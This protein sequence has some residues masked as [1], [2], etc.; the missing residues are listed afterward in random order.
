M[1]IISPPEASEPAVTVD[2]AVA[3]ARYRLEK[4]LENRLSGW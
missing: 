4:H 3:A 2:A 1:T